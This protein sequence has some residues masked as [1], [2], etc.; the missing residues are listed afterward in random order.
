NPSLN[1]ADITHMPG[2]SL[3]RDYFG[4]QRL[5]K[6]VQGHLFSDGSPNSRPEGIKAPAIRVKRIARYQAH[7]L[8]LFVL[9]P[10]I[11]IQYEDRATLIMECDLELQ[12]LQRS[13]R[14]AVTSATVDIDWCKPQFRISGAGA[15]VVPQYPSRPRSKP[16]DPNRWY[17]IDI[18]FA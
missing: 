4:T 2:Q 5:A 10:S 11:H 17:D 1:P 7:Q 13:D 15:S 16:Y 18:Q 8:A 6:T 9:P 3:A 12:F 14:K